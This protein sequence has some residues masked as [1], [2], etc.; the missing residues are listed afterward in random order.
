MIA[1]FKREFKSFFTNVTGPLFIS[2]LLC[3]IGIYVMFINL[4]G[5]YSSFEY[6]LSNVSMV[7]L[8]IVPILTM[9]SFAEER[10]SKTDQLLY[11]LPMG[12]GSIVLGKYL[13]MLAVLAI[14]TAIAALYPLILGTL[15][16]VAYGSAYLALFSFFLLG[17]ALIAVGM[18]MSSLT[19]SQVIAAVMSFGVLLLMYMMKSLSAL[20]PQTKE[21]SLICF[22]VLSAV[23]A[24]VLYS[25]TKST[26]VSVV[27]FA[28][29]A[30]VT[31]VFYYFKS[32]AF[33][34]LFG[35]VIS[36]LAVFE[37]FLDLTEGVFDLTAVVYLISVAFFFVYL[38]CRSV[39]K[40]RYA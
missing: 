29:L 27:L 3:F 31:A 16:E 23:L 25:L 39:E 33:A 6:S 2:F 7:L 14:P 30:F 11:S 38:T 21:A 19:E 13:A 20:V 24:L 4:R 15:G 12:I 9:R 22:L 35:R 26:A 17:A 37:R 8:L 18:F 28:A 40:R 1:V 10:H 32:A 34:G 5:G 36:Y